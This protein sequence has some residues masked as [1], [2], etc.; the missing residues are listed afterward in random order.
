MTEDASKQNLAE[1]GA[2]LGG[3]RCVCGSSVPAGTTTCGTCNRC[4]DASVL[5]S[6]TAATAEFD[7]NHS[8]LSTVRVGRPDLDDDVFIDRK[9]G[10]FRILERI[11][12]G[13]MGAVYR[14]LD[15]SLERYVAVKVLRPSAIG[16]DDSRLDRL[17]QEARAQARV[18]HPH[19]AHTYYIG[20]EDETPYL[21]MELVGTESL[22][23]RL[24]NGPLPFRDVARYGYQIATALQ[25]ASGFDIVHGDVKPANMLLVDDQTVKLSDF[26]LASQM[27][28]TDAGSGVVSGTPNYMPPEAMSGAIDHRGD[29][30]SLGVTLFEMT[31]GRL[32]YDGT[33]K[34][35]ESSKSSGSSVRTFM[36][37]HQDAVIEFPQPWPDD[38]PEQWR[39]ILSRLLAKKPER[40]YESFEQLSV[41]LRAVQ[42]TVLPAA[43]PLLRGL[44]WVGDLFVVALPL[45]LL[46]T[47]PL[48]MDGQPWAQGLRWGASLIWLASIAAVQAAWGTT[49]GKQLFQIRIVDQHGMKPSRSA[50][51]GRSV[52][53][54]AVPWALTVFDALLGLLTLDAIAGAFTVVAV[55]LLFVEFFTVV[56]R[57]GRSVHDAIF[58]TRVTLDA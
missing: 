35:I 36:K 2:D 22:A 8:A 23:D 58:K 20:L 44:A 5:N 30:Y 43:S 28:G 47:L 19:V 12:R 7:P 32:P 49:P 54:F 57:R 40:R 53:Q 6:A 41:A 16:G 17:F 24:R 3:Y 27:T 52:F 48:L 26:G 15:E 46:A 38:L 1:T 51:G 55:V 18:S 37:L 10:H 25:A 56:F 4:Y 9:L 14:A 29:M 34:A 13:G 21:A 33:K 45:A 50:L 11:G 31:F 39:G 42:P